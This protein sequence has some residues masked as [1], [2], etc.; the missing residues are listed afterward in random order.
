MTEEWEIN[1]CNQLEEKTHA[2]TD[3]YGGGGG[4]WRHVPIERR[5]DDVQRKEIQNPYVFLLGIELLPSSLQLFLDRGSTISY[6]LL[7]EPKL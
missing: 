7:S 1:F 6:A 2:E 3:R 5:T 4:D